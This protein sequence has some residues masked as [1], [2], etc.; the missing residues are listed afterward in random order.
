MTIIEE[1]DDIEARLEAIEQTLKEM[2]EWMSNIVNKLA[3]NNQL[4]IL[5]KDDEK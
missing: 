4:N 5:K 2:T 1:I 3:E